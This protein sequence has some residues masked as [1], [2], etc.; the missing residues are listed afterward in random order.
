[1]KVVKIENKRK[2]PWLA[3]L[4]N[5]PETSQ[6]GVEMLEGFLGHRG[7]RVAIE[8]K[9]SQFSDAIKRLFR[10]HS[11]QV[12]AEVKNLKRDNIVL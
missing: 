8:G 7:H 5:S 9:K 6:A 2:R 12:E 4:R 3:R 1:M 10:Q 11:D